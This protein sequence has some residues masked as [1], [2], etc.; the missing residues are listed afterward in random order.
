MMQDDVK[1]HDDLKGVTGIQHECC[2]RQDA[3]FVYYPFSV[4][5]F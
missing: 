1:N 3:R 4:S 2:P 5:L